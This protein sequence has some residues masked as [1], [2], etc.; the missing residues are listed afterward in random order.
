MYICTKLAVCSLVTYKAV[1]TET[2]MYQALCVV[3]G[4][5][6]GNNYPAFDFWL[7]GLSKAL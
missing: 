7:P 1:L 6:R 2:F 5:M 3:H 4:P